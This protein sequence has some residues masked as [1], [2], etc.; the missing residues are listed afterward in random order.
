MRVLEYYWII[1]VQQGS[2]ITTLDGLAAIE[3]PFTRQKLVECIREQIVVNTAADP[4]PVRKD[5]V[6]LFLDF[7][8]NELP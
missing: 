7:G 1:T 2:I 5:H 6:V 8:P 3:L 4:H